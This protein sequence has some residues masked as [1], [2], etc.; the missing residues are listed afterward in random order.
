[1]KIIAQNL[2][3]T[4]NFAR[5]LAKC[6]SQLKNT[7]VIYLIGDLGCGKTTIAQN[8][9]QFFGFDRIKSPTYTLVESYEKELI[10]IHHFDLYRINSPEELEYI[11]I[12][13]YIGL[14]VIQLIEWPKL[15]GKFIAKADIFINITDKNNNKRIIEI[16]SNSKTGDK[17]LN[18]YNI[19][20]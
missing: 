9:I 4:Q 7:L 16:E 8:F 13:D 2:E 11:G 1:M 14:D 15:G 17:M 10:K 6:Y 3:D 12:K 5:N 19:I 20:N 18:L